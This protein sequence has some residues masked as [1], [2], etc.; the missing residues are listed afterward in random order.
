MKHSLNF[1][2]VFKDQFNYPMK[3]NP[4]II[5]AVFLFF[6]N[7]SCTNTK[8][9]SSTQ[10]EYLFNGTD[11][12]G[13]VKKNGQAPYQVIDSAI[14]GTTILNTPNSFLCTDRNFSDFILELEFKVDPSMNSGVQFRSNSYP[15]YQDSRVHGYQFEIDPSD[16]AFTGGIYDEA[17]R[18]WLYPLSDNEN[19]EARSAFKNGAWNKFRIEAIGNCIKTWVNGVPVTKLYDDADSTGFIALQVHSI[20]QDS[21]MLGKQI[22]WKNIRIIT[23]DPQKYATDSPAKTRSFLVNTLTKEEIAEGWKLLFDGQSSKGWRKAYAEIFPE[24]GWKIENGI[25]SVL[26]ATGAESQN[27]GDIVT[28]DEY[29]NFELLLQTKITDGA[30]SGVKYFVTEQEVNNPGSAIG[31]EYQI[32]DD[33]L[34]PDAKLGNHE[35]SRTFASLYD[36]IKAQNKRVNAMGQWNNVRIISLNNHVEHWLN[37]FKVLEYDR[38]SAEFRKLVSESKYK[39]FKAFG[40]AEKGHILLQDHGNEVFFRSIKLREIK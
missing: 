15:E 39:D 21:A 6:A 13:W 36:L 9:D 24:K 40:E 12:T 23:K 31:L 17:R 3:K 30:N 19:S 14:V 11:L 37:G 29:S 25:L 34:H 7:V 26:P 38:G 16:R 10:W 5:L 27:G 8:R 35:G 33:V 20:G 18:G 1:K 22:M 32:L 28:V 2:R 4:I